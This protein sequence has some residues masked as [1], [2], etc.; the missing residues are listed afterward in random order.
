MVGQ[1]ANSLKKWVKPGGL[2]AAQSC[3][4]DLNYLGEEWFLKCPL[5]VGR[6]GNYA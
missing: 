2:P 4:Y 5:S 1:P 6:K 3:F